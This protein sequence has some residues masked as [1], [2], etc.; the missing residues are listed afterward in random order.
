MVIDGQTGSFVWTHG[1]ADQPWNV[2][3][4]TY[5]S[6]D[7]INDVIVGTLFSNNYCY[8]LD[9]TDGT[10][11]ESISYGQAVDA[12]AAVSDA[13]GDGSMEMVAGGRNGKVTCI[14]GGLDAVVNEPPTK[15]IIDGPVGAAVGVVY[16]FTFVASDPNL[17][18]VYYYID[19]DDGNIE[20]WIGPYSSGQ[21]ITINHSWTTTGTY[22]VT[23]KA[24][25]DKDMEG[26][27]SDPHIVT[28]VENQPPDTPTIEGPTSGKAGIEYDYTFKSNDNDGNPFYFYVDWGDGNIET[29]I[30][31]YHS[32]EEVIL[33]HTWIERGTYIIL[34]KVRDV[35]LE[36]SGWG[37]LE[38]SIPRKR[39]RLNQLII[40]ILERF[41]NTFPILR[42][43]M[44]L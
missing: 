37:S 1:V 29:D 27:E 42:Q 9:G 26:P 33:S 38:V 39:I 32:G 14:S 19:W 25:D 28:V 13:V 35:Y 40:Q 5:V 11:L 18:P 30:G 22:Y 7:G 41:P 6:G 4:I 10:E 16:D 21:I 36:E 31:P 44:G 3:R 12:I 23:A 20:E 34:S 8:F 2:D 17:D 15:T 43:L 24:K